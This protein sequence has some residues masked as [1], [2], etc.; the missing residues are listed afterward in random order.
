[1]LLVLILGFV[2]GAAALLF[3]TENT[4]VVAL[5]FLQWQFQASI[6]LLI[7]AAILVGIV[8]MALTV[9]PGAIGDSF[10][11]RR[12]QRRNEALAREAEAQRQAAMRAHARL[13]AAN[14]SAPNVLDLSST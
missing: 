3:I 2:L 1:M 10:R 13:A 11:M 6:A 9:L 12:L 7:L 8:L 14:G 5:T 4:A